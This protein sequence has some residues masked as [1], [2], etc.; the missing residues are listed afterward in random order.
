MHCDKCQ[1]IMKLSRRRF[2]LIVQNALLA[3]HGEIFILSL[4][5]EEAAHVDRTN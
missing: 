3:I 2:T 4:F 1:N 5:Q